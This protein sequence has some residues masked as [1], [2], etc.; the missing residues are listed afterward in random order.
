MFSL[1]CLFLK[2]FQYGLQ[3]FENTYVCVFLILTMGI[4]HGG[5]DHIKG[6][7]LL[8]LYSLKS[9]VYFYGSY[10]GLVVSTFYIWF[11]FPEFII[12]NFLIVAS[13]HFGKED[14]V[15][16]KPNT[17]L[18]AWYILNLLYIGKGSL[19]ISLPLF[20]H[21][22][23][24]IQIFSILNFNGF[25]QVK[26]IELG[27]YLGLLCCVLLCFSFA[28][29][30]YSCSGIILDMLSLIL[31]NYSLTP[32]AAFSYYFCF[33]HSI[34]HTIHWIEQ[35]YKSNFYYGL[36]LFLRKSFP[37]TLITAFLSI[38]TFSFFLQNNNLME[39]I[40][41]V[42]FIGLSALTFPHIILESLIEVKKNKTLIL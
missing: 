22:D 2:N 13:F 29:N 11:Y 18:S 19:V 28:K 23:H 3:F 12:V 6:R 32:L 14:S 42:S 8:D 5:L 40:I 36:K 4:S 1:F 41:I 38:M 35:T 17:D 25:D 7:Y 33:L 10:M 20:F 24:T 26:F 15:C 9:M 21:Y 31:F 27:V 39:S 37:L 34:R 30:K 16:F